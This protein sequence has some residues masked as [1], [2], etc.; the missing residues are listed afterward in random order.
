MS[1]E[2][3]KTRVNESRAARMK[4]ERALLSPEDKDALIRKFHPDYKKEAYRT[5]QI[6][7]NQGEQTVHELA[8]LLEGKARSLPKRFPFHPSIR[9]TC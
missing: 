7:P 5:I 4:E 8:N 6:G 1:L 3:S 9:W 2:D